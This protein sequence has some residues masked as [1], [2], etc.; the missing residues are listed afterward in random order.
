MQFNFNKLQRWH[1]STMQKLVFQKLLVFF[2]MI[3]S[4]LLLTRGYSVIPVSQTLI[5]FKPPDNL[6]Q[7]SFPLPVEHCNLTPDFLNCLIFE[8]NFN[9]VSLGGSK[10]SGFHCIHVFILVLRYYLL[11]VLYYCSVNSVVVSS[12]LYRPPGK[13]C[14]IDHVVGNQP[15]DAMVSIAEWYVHL[16]Y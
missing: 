9:L 13:L 7:W 6:N 2:G 12:L 15:E 16:P 3:N 1:I 11:V 10:K 4:I 5:F 14:F 8:T